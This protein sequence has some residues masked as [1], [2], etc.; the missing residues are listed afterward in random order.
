LRRHAQETQFQDIREQLLRLA[1]SY[2]RLAQTIDLERQRKI[3]DAKRDAAND[4]VSF[5]TKTP[6]GANWAGTFVEPRYW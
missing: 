4:D 6:P 3:C 2:D 1:R 5:D